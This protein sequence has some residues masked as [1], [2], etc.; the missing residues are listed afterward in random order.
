M[1]QF[2]QHG[3]IEV[4]NLACR[5]VSEVHTAVN[6]KRWIKEI[7]AEYGIEDKNIL[8]LTVDAAA[9]IQKAARLILTELRDNTFS[10]DCIEFKDESDEIE[11]EK[12]SDRHILHDTITSSSENFDEEDDELTGHTATKM[13]PTSFRVPCVVH[14]LQ[15]GVNKW[16]ESSNVS[17]ILTKAHSIV[18]RLRTP[19][20]LRL[21]KEEKLL[22]PVLDQDTRWSSKF[23]SIERLLD[24]KEF[25]H[26]SGA[27]ELREFKPNSEF[28]NRLTHIRDLLKPLAIL[29]TALQS[30][31][32]TIPK[33]NEYWK[34]AELDVPA[35]NF[36]PGAELLKLI[37]ARRDKINEN[38]IVLTGMYLDPRIKKSLS[39]PQKET[40]QE[41]LMAFLK[42]FS[43]SEQNVDASQTCEASVEPP[44]RFG[45]LVGS[46]NARQG[47]VN[48]GH[49][50]LQTQLESY[51][52]DCFGENVDYT[53]DPTE[54]WLKKL[55]SSDLNVQ[56]IAT[57]ALKITTCPLTEVTSERLFSLLGFVYN[58][59]RC[60]LKDDI[61]EDILFCK[62]NSNQ[63]MKSQSTP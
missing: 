63:K 31:T 35:I 5:Q 25:C 4:W 27:R 15:L 2:E 56:N 59:L 11:I 17:S 38:P 3:H 19:R 40:A 9:N 61:I 20:V 42:R 43:I 57:A 13:V 8:T 21:I 52:H 23:R 47:I 54:F 51:D 30:E 14:Q 33:F 29:T 46:L 12:C 58:K 44:N 60:S 6:V 16:C 34:T 7:L 45:K 37:G 62:W 32:L 55:E 36:N 10:V 26:E 50:S 24:L 22:N 39:S 18:V 1:V 53:C 49:N 28:W 41:T 48:A